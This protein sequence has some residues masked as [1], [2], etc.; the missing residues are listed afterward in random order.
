MDLKKIQIKNVR[1]S[2]FWV[3]SKYEVVQTGFQDFMENLT[4]QSVH[5]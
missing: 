1:A 5:P 4:T 3:C 2:L